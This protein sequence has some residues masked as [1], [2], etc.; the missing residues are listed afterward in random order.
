MIAERLIWV[1]GFESQDNVAFGLDEKDVSAHG[2]RWE[3]LVSDISAGIFRGADHGL[4]VVAVEVEGMFARVVAVDNDFDDLAFLEDEGVGR[5][6]VDVRIVDKGARGEGCVQRWNFGGS[7]ALIVEEGTAGQVSKMIETGSS[8]FLLI[9][10]VTEY[11]HV[12]IESDGVVH[13]VVECETI[14]RHK[15]EIVERF[16][17][18][19]QSRSG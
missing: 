14:M 13:F 5:T 2:H 18:V 10:T 11:T 15:G 17:I 16:E 19:D 4:E 8:E 6:A 12:E 1:I 7:I 3:S 9:C